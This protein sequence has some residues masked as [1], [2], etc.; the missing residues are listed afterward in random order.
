MK[1]FHYVHYLYLVM[2]VLFIYQGITNVQNGENSIVSFL[3]A[4]VAI[5][6]FFFRRHFSN[7]I[8]NNTK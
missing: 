7:K 6:M 4:G 5:F 3:F 2:G 8:K 1:I